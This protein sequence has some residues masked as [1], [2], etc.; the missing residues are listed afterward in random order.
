MQK[1]PV[2]KEPLQGKFWCQACHTVLVCPNPRCGAQQRK[3]DAASCPDCGMIFEP[4]ITQRKKVR[5]CPKCKKRQGLLE[6]RCQSCRFWFNCPTCG[7]KIT[8]TSSL[9]CPRCATDL[10]R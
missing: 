9:T 4:F 2:C 3:R 1:C 5:E 7:H 6:Q 8:S 10:R